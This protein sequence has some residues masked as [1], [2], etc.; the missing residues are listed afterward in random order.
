MN[1]ILICSLEGVEEP[2]EGIRE[3]E[4]KEF[5]EREHKIA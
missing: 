3:H 5:L 4:R 2:K 1:S